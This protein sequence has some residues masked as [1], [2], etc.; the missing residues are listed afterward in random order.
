MITSYCLNPNL[1]LN[2]C[3]AVVLQSTVFSVPNYLSIRFL[4]DRFFGSFTR[5]YLCF[6]CSERHFTVIIRKPLWPNLSSTCSLFKHNIPSLY[7][8]I[9]TPFFSYAYLLISI[10][11]FQDTVLISTLCK[12][13]DEMKFRINKN[14]IN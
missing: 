6:L 8:I 10:I 4:L 1:P 2:L 7:T 9:S 12:T 5:F 3:A 11:L 13:F 14:H